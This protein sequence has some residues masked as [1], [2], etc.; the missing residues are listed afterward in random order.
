MCEQTDSANEVRDAAM[1]LSRACLDRAPASYRA[2]L[3]E[4]LK[5]PLPAWAEEL[6]KRL[7]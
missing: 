3:E 7:K 5:D 2:N 1:C 6:L 4:T